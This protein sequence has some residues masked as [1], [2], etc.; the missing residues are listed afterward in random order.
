M[1]L[2]TAN[3]HKRARMLNA[4]VSMITCM[5]KGKTK[6]KFML[7]LTK[8]ELRLST[9]DKRREFRFFSNA[10]NDLLYVYIEGPLGPYLT[11]C[12]KHRWHKTAKVDMDTP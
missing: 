2:L 4:N 9:Q 1:G 6:V 11:P 12:A 10:P 3:H 7:I 5:S 8:I